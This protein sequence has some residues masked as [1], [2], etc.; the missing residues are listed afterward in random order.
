MASITQKGISFAYTYD[1]RGNITS[2]TRTD[3]SGNSL[4][5]SYVYDALGQLIRVNDPHEN[6]TWV[7]NYDRG[8]NITSK[9]KYAYIVGELPPLNKSFY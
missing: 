5:T 9:D 3:A 6:A 7:Y 2:E 8:G 4:T 1:S